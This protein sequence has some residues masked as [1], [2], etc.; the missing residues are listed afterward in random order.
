MSRSDSLHDSSPCIPTFISD[1][2][3]LNT[4][5]GGTQQ[6]L[7]R[8][9]DIR[10]TMNIYGDAATELVLSSAQENCGNITA[11]DVTDSG[12]SNCKL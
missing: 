1:V 9:S 3:R 10:T 2:D 11:D 7:M 4:P 8:N 12:Q 5:V 6:K